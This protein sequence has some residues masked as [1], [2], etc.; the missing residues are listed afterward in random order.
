MERKILERKIL[1]MIATPYPHKYNGYRA[2]C[3]MQQIS[4][5]LFFLR[6]LFRLSKSFIFNRLRESLLIVSP[7]SSAEGRYTRDKD[8]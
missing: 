7:H 3:N 5:T 1:A 6:D 2:T 8:E 4:Y